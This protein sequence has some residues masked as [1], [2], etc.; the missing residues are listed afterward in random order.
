MEIGQQVD[1]RVEKEIE[2]KILDCCGEKKRLPC[3]LARQIAEEFKVRPI[4]VGQIADGL[5]VKISACE[6]G[7][8]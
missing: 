7:C 4:V 1:E 2:R 8:F 3:P 5:G 6:L